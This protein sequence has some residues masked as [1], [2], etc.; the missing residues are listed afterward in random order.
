MKNLLIALPVFALAAC[1]SFDENASE[2]SAYASQDDYKERQEAI[3]KELLVRG[4]AE[5]MDEALSLA[6]DELNKE[7]A[8]RAKAAEEKQRQADFDRAL[9][10]VVKDGL[11]DK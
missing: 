5:T 3:A 10:D 11:S 7:W 9:D 2:K 6:N 8:E 4:E 1:S